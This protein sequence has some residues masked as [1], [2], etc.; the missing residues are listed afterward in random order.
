STLIPRPETEEMVDIIIRENKY[1][2]GNIAD[3]GTGSGCIAIA[4]AANIPGAVITGID[5]SEEA[6]RVARENAR[7]N[8]VSIS[9]IKCDILNFN[10][11]LLN[12]TGIIVSNPP[13]IRNSE[14]QFMNK[15]VLDFEPSQAL[16]VPDSDPLKFYSAI[17]KIAD[18]IL[19]PGGKIY[20]EINEAMGKSMIQLFESFGY[21]EIHV[22][23]DINNK[24]RIIKGVKN[25]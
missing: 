14:K 7:M 5:I 17:L 24:E 20:F 10:S 25:G 6:L 18:K 11:R 8:N 12:K 22:I 13:Y 1:F 19:N 3:L 21:S 23:R 15:N 4:L 2:K 9:Y 16:F